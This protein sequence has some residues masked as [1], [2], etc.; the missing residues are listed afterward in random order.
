M[1]EINQNKYT[2]AECLEA[3]LKRLELAIAS[4]VY[5]V[6]TI[7]KHLRNLTRSDSNL[8]IRIAKDIITDIEGNSYERESLIARRDLLRSVLEN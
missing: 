3:E 7:I 8:A 6:A 5:D 2:K 4:Y 1:L